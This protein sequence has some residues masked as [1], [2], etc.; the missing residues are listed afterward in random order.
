M[1]PLV[2]FSLF[3][4]CLLTCSCWVTKPVK[5][6]R[7]HDYTFQLAVSDGGATTSFS[8]TVTAHYPGW[9]GTRE[10][11]LFQ[12]YGGPYL[13]DIQVEDN[14]LVLLTKYNGEPQ[15]IELDLQ[16]V[17]ALLDDPIEYHRYQPQQSN[18][19]Y[20]EPGFIQAERERE[21]QFDMVLRQRRLQRDAIKN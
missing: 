20:R 21:E 16:H 7:W 19:F 18:A 17:D 12:A 4:L 3:L 11:T 14:Q 2:G 5:Q 1:K 15:R 6:I 13:T 9:F 10:K 8:W